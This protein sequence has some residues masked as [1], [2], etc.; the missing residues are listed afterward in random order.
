MFGFRKKK[1]SIDKLRSGLAGIALEAIHSTQKDAL[2]EFSEFLQINEN[3]HQDYGTN[4]YFFMRMPIDES[5]VAYSLGFVFGVCQSY[6]KDDDYAGGVFAEFAV[7]YEKTID[8]YLDALGAKR[9]DTSFFEKFQRIWETGSI[10]N[11]DLLS[12]IFATALA[13]GK[14]YADVTRE[15]EKNYSIIKRPS[16]IERLNL[17]C[18]R[19]II[20]AWKKVAL[21]T[22]EL[23][24]L[25]RMPIHWD[26]EQIDAELIRQGFNPEDFK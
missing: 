6:G 17:S 19:E 26:D 14:D 21:S 24:V 23:L 10:Q 15:I 25:G 13:E 8:N 9:F 11:N 22:R 2:D 7:A 1:E 3:C 12:G 18:F 4:M 20:D 16:T 5:V